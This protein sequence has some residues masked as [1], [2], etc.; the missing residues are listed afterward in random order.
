MNNDFCQEI[1]EDIDHQK[2]ANEMNTT[3]YV[4]ELSDESLGYCFIANLTSTNKWMLSTGEIVNVKK[5][6]KQ[7]EPQTSGHKKAPFFFTAR[8][9]AN[10]F[11]VDMCMKYKNAHYT[12]EMKHAGKRKNIYRVLIINLTNEQYDE[13]M[14]EGAKS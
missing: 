13:L 2:L 7:F 14:K 10:D 5:F 12:V 9:A 8:K 1:R 3:V 6:V 4:Y 11:G